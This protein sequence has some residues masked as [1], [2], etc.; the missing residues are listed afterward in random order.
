MSSRNDDDKENLQENHH[1]LQEELTKLQEQR[2]KTL[3]N[4]RSKKQLLEE[5]QRAHQATQQQLQQLQTQLTSLQTENAKLR[6]GLG[7]VKAVRDELRGKLAFHKELVKETKAECLQ[8]RK[9][10]AD[11]QAIRVLE[12]DLLNLYRKLSLDTGYVKWGKPIRKLESD[13]AAAL[14]QP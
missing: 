9:D 12:Q 5:T 7:K 13:L 3:Q 10:W 8:L 6:Q 2:A 11:E 4:L 14:Q 1:T